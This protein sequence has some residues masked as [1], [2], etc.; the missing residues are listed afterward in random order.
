MAYLAEEDWNVDVD[1]HHDIQSL[2]RIRSIDISTQLSMVYIH[3]ET[4]EQVA[5]IVSALYVSLSGS[6]VTRLNHHKRHAYGKILRIGAKVVAI[7]GI[8][9]VQNSTGI[10]SC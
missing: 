5:M 8:V 4:F 6:S 9:Q 1:V 2:S 10:L 7:A 3:T